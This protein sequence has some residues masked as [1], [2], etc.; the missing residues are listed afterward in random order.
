[1][2]K[3]LV[4]FVMAAA[5]VACLTGVEP[6]LAKE[7]AGGI[8]G[9]YASPP[10]FQIYEAPRPYGGLIM[11]DTQTGDSYQRVIVNTAQG[12]E[13]RWIKLDRSKGVQPNETILWE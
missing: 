6:S 11:L 13:I 1:M 9:V 3:A 5:L 12:I 2:K 10:R 7:P 4:M 8:A